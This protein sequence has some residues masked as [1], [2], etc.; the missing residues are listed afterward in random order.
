MPEGS[1]EVAPGPGTK[2]QLSSYAAR[3]DT[4]SCLASKQ[5][6]T[7]AGFVPGLSPVGGAVQGLKGA[8]PPQ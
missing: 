4:S 7:G 3:E 2:A 8:E 1:S 6:G 5:R